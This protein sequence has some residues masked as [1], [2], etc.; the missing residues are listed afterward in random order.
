MVVAVGGALGAMSRFGVGLIFS[1]PHQF[2]WATLLVN[3]LGCLL[4][5]L[6][7]QYVAFK[8]ISYLSPMIIVGFL[9]G[10]TTFSSFG[11]ESVMMFQQREFVKL[12]WY[13]GVSNIGGIAAV[14]LGVMAGK[15]FWPQTVNF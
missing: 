12:F 14:L 9:G 1:T 7:F 10:F 11:F 4:I 2:P 13:V 3:I 5:G 8:N 15:S 6:A